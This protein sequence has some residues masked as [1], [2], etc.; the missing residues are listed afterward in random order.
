MQITNAAAQQQDIANLKTSTTTEQVAARSG[1][2]PNSF[3]ASKVQSELNLQ[4]AV[5]QEFDTNRQQAKAQINQGIDQAKADLKSGTLSQ[6]EYEAKVQNLQTA[7]VLLDSAAAGLYVPNSN[8][9]MGTVAK[10]ASPQVAQQIGSYFKE[11]AQDGSA[12]HLVAHAVL[13]AA[14]AAATG[15]DAVT[16]GVSAATA[17][18]AVP[19]V[20]NW[21]YGTSDPDKLSAEQKGTISA[22]VGLAGA[23]AGATTA[24]NAGIVAS[25]SAAQNAVE[26]NWDLLQILSPSS[27][28]ALSRISQHHQAMLT[29]AGLR[30]LGNAVVIVNGLPY[31]LGVGGSALV[32]LSGAG[33]A[34]PL[35]SDGV[36]GVVKAVSSGAAAG[37][38]LNIAQQLWNCG[39][40]SSTCF[41]NLN[42]VSVGVSSGVAAATGGA[43]NAMAQGAAVGQM[44][45]TGLLK[46]GINI[47]RYVKNNP[48]SMV[49]WLNQTSTGKIF[50]L[51][52]QSIVNKNNSSE[53]K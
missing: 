39:S 34:I 7:G 25:G 12:A 1:T 43:A 46:N 3:D 47:V 38:T 14:V 27:A 35:T 6:S 45:T 49:I 37:T 16:A 19:K 40:V 21:L 5:T 15:T 26:N 4:T 2:L 51:S 10:M 11:N 31:V 13:G 48:S 29:V 33:A 18:G 53:G 44:T 8:G 42:W 41:D 50:N 17:E 30:K 52:G 20:A 32:P 9:A 24:S 28:A 22:I 36:V 23:A